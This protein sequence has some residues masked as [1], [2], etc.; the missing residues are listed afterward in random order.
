MQPLVWYVL[1]YPVVDLST[2]PALDADKLFHRSTEDNEFM[3][4]KITNAELDHEAIN[5][6]EITGEIKSF[7]DNVSD[8][9]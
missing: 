2:L 8:F 5:A 4:Y 7:M 6:I 3:S 9:A 1:K